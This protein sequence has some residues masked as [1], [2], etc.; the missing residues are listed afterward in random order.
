MYFEYKFTVD[1]N[2][3]YFFY[4]Y[5]KII[6]FEYKFTDMNDCNGGTLVLPSGQESPCPVLTPLPCHP[7]KWSPCSH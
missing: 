7:E 5:K 2:I 4:N 6:Y 1:K 3:I